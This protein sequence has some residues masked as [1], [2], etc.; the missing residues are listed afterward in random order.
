MKVLLEQDGIDVNKA[1]RGGNFPLYSASGNGHAEVVKALLKQ[2]T[3]EANK[4]T[5][6]GGG[7]T[8]LCI[9]CQEGHAEVVRLLLAHDRIEANK[10]A[11]DDGT[12]P[13][14]LACESGHADVVRLLL[15][16]NGIA[17]NAVWYHSTRHMR[18]RTSTPLSVACDGGHAEVVTLLLAHDGIEVNTTSSSDDPTPLSLA[19]SNGHSEVVKLLL[20][21]DGIDVNKSLAATGATPLFYAC[22]KG[23]V[24]IVELLLRHSTI[25]VNQPKH[26]GITPLHT[27]CSRSHAEVVKLLLGRADLKVD[28]ARTDNF[29]TPLYTA[30]SKEKGLV[31]IVRLLLADGRANVNKP[32]TRS[33]SSPLHGAVMSKSIAVAQVLVVHGASLT[34]TNIAT[35]TAQQFACRIR[36]CA[37]LADWLGAVSGWSQ[38]EVAAGFRLHK[39]AAAA[40]KVGKI[41][42][43]D[44]NT[45]FAEAIVATLATSKTKVAALP[46]KAGR[47]DYKRYNNVWGDA[48]P[49][50]KATIKLVADATR[51][52]HRTTH[53]L[54]HVNVRGAIF[55]VLVVA[56]RLDKTSGGAAAI[57]E[58]EAGDAAQAVPTSTPPLPVLPVE[59]W[60]FAMQFVL[61]SWWAAPSAAGNDGGG[62]SMSSSEGDTDSDFVLPQSGD[63]GS[64]GSDD[65][66]DDDVD[67]FA[68]FVEVEHPY[69]DDDHGDDGDGLDADGWW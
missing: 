2:G 16:H 5:P 6:D 13:L 9:A 68:G 47:Q 56:G 15:A 64:D 59:I 58:D 18:I 66:D 36:N 20:E 31:E 62:D 30:C 38:L 48:P 17:V 53:W 63:D 34:A 43:D 25:N 1:S 14:S 35:H 37:K 61:R 52:W 40:L 57:K 28:K 3:I 8:S 54:H 29:V 26:G 51:G 27:A 44:P 32:G 11:F 10:I 19:C 42:P 60:L 4:S 41:D 12:T 69:Y 46:I 39:D 65:D 67:N 21:H 7:G 50:C 33:G 24:E 45:A 23:F 55:A 22:K 49:I